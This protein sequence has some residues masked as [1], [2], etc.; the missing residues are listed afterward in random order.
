MPVMDEAVT[1]GGIILLANP[2]RKSPPK[3]MVMA[4]GPQVDEV[5]EGDV[6][7]FNQH[8]VKTIDVEGTEFIVINVYEILAKITTNDN[9]GDNTT[10]S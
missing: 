10:G 8:A 4:I 6:V 1:S 3:G 7:Y 5:A 9:S 2:D